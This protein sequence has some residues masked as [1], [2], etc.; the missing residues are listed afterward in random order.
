MF[1]D[2][3][4]P[5]HNAVAYKTEGTIDLLHEYGMNDIVMIPWN[6]ETAGQ[7]IE[8][9]SEKGFSVVA[10]SQ[11]QTKGRSVAPIWAKYL[12]DTYQHTDKSFGLL[13][14]PWEY[15]YDTPEGIKRLRT[16]A[17]Y[18]WSSAPYIIHTPVKSTSSGNAIEIQAIVQGDDI[19]FDGSKL[20]KGS[21]PVVS[22]NVYYRAIGTITYTVVPMK[23][24]GNNY[25]AHIPADVFSQ[26][27]LEYYIE[28]ADIIHNSVIPHSIPEYPF[29]I[30][31]H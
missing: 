13:H 6:Y 3:L 26:T 28:V 5:F 18:S 17:D 23:K 25:S 31:V 4:D 8:Y 22:A 19:V 7:I 12:R 9:F 21:L 20:K 16:A 24:D 30:I 14:A 10:S 1:S 2:M 11:N 15:D 29:Q 27:G